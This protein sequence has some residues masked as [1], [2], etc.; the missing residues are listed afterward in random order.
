[1]KQNKMISMQPGEIERLEAL[2][3]ERK[4][5]VSHLINRLV[6][7]EIRR[8]KNRSA[9]RAAYKPLK[10]TASTEVKEQWIE[11]MDRRQQK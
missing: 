8:E 5:P 2:A 1:M 7:E 11:R 10:F 3:A 9:K 4:L 6:I